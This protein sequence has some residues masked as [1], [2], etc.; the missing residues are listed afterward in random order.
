MIKKAGEVFVKIME[1]YICHEG[2][3]AL[4]YAKF[5]WLKPWNLKYRKLDSSSSQVTLTIAYNQNILVSI[6]SSFISYYAVLNKSCL[7]LNLKGIFL[8]TVTDDELMVSATYRAW[9]WPNL[10]TLGGYIHI[11]NRIKVYNSMLLFRLGRLRDN[12]SHALVVS[13]VE[14]LQLKILYFN[15]FCNTSNAHFV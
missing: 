4:A 12:L 15:M 13:K 3:S 14:I 11:K 5:R 9:Y 7:I 10:R 6:I 1:F 8:H 2:S